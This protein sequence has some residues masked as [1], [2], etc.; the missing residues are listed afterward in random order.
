MSNDTL[1]PKMAK[2]FKE[3][4]VS[5]GDAKLIPVGGNGVVILDYK[6]GKENRIIRIGA[7]KAKKMYFCEIYRNT[8]NSK[9][10]YDFHVFHSSKQL[11]ALFA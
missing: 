9:T 1:M 2:A 11:I 8:N 4:G 7:N 6:K 5:L 10:D 3:L